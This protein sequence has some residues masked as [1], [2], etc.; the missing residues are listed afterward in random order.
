[1]AN[2]TPI[3]VFPAELHIRINNITSI[4]LKMVM[5]LW[6]SGKSLFKIGLKMG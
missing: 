5:R 6:W 2:V 3:L 1:M 4:I